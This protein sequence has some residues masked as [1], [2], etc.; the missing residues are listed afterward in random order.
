MKHLPKLPLIR[1][2]TPGRGPVA[3]NRSGT[4]PIPVI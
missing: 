4:Y 3:A 2:G 1:I